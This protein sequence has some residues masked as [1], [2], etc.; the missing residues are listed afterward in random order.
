MRRLSTS[1]LIGGLLVNAANAGVSSRD[2]KTPGDGLLTY[3]DV[4]RR[5]WLDLSVSLTLPVPRF[6]S[7][8]AELEPG[9]IV[10]GFTIAKRA[11]IV[12]MAESAGIQVEV[13][14][15]ATNV[16]ATDRLIDLLGET[17]GSPT[18]EFRTATGLLDETVI[19]GP[20]RI[21]LGALFQYSSTSG[22]GGYA[23]L[24]VVSHTDG[25]S[26]TG[27]AVYLY[28]EVI[29]EPSCVALAIAAVA[30]FI[31]KLKLST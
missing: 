6:E 9:G 23:G 22:S 4:N 27:S 26:Q 17:R 20:P 15:F 7:V 24:S 18:G 2:W 16:A 30:C 31:L 19:M 29:P 11:D 12:S 21:R 28:R 5:E 10:Q 3:D 25:L 1:L 13:F 14:D 8:I